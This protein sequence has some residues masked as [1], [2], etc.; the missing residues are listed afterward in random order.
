M[1][2][3]VV[4]K[5]PQKGH[6]SRL[7]NGSWN[8]PTVAP[9][10]RADATVDFDGLSTGAL[11]NQL[12]GSGLTFSDGFVVKNGTDA[13]RVVVPSPPNYLDLDRNL[14]GGVGTVSF[15]SP[16]DEGVPAVT[17]IVSIHEPRAEQLR[18]DRLVQRNSVRR[19]RRNR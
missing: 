6:S 14:S 10:L 3:Q 15:V 18:R 12:A 13:S 8:C 11:G 19:A 1:H 5:S 4:I 2:S 16:L 9:Q 17:S 7:Q